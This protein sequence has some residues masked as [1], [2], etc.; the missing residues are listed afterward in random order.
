MKNRIEE[1]QQRIE[2]SQCWDSRYKNFNLTR[3][4]ADKELLDMRCGIIKKKGSID[5]SRKAI[6]RWVRNENWKKWIFQPTYHKEEEKIY[7][8]PTEWEMIKFNKKKLK[9]IREQ[10]SAWAKKNRGN[11]T[12]REK[13]RIMS[14]NAAKR[15]E[16]VKIIN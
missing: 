10:K 14:R 3:E 2:K 9:R 6:V 15:W 12:K 13:S 8:Y 7:Y 1:I 16:K 4:G 5:I 11:L